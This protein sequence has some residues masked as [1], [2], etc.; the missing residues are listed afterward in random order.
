[1]QK[2]LSLLVCL[3]TILPLL[4]QRTLLI[5]QL[6]TSTPAGAEIYIAGDF[7]GWQPG[8]PA[9]RLN[10][11][12]TTGNYAITL[13]SGLGD[14][15]FKFTRGDWST[16][17]VDATGTSISNRFL[18]AGEGDTVRLQI[19]GWDDLDGPN[20]NAST[21]ESNVRILTDS[22]YMASLDRYRRVWL[23]LPPDYD[24]TTQA[25]P[26]LYMHDGQNVFDAS[27]S[28]AG[29]WQVDETLNNLHAAG[30]R[31]IIVVAIDNGQTLR[32]REYSA[33][34]NAR[35]GG[36]EGADYI[37]F[38]VEELKPYIDANYRTLPDRQH[39]GIMGSSLGGLISLFAGIEHQEVFGKVGALSPA[40]WFNPEAFEHVANTGK[41]AEMRIYQIAGTQEGAQYVEE[42]F[43]MDDQLEAAGF[44]S[45][46][47]RTL[48]HADGQHSE[49]YWAREFAAAYEWLFGDATTSTREIKLVVNE[50]RLYPNPA[51][52]SL[53]LEFKLLQAAE[54]Q[55]ELVDTKGAILQAS[56]A[57]KLPAGVHE[58]TLQLDRTAFSAGYYIC[59]LVVSDRVATVPFI[60][61]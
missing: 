1:M 60:V 55:L 44:D 2:L 40:Y 26:V 49:W 30:D 31:G 51:Q 61:R 48:E 7:Q 50:L 45:E 6:P 28:F 41:E 59:R 43:E 36:G 3:V 35:Y 11:D 14:I 9:Y 42:M 53:L 21:A 20:G 32:S 47:V 34:P 39:T 24:Q 57:Q 52:D 12:S 10:E 33:W 15:Q 58:L 22:F 5:D 54:V 23:Y 56:P 8:D 17:E 27:T 16:V 13:P 4:A 46:E 25:Y 29:E 19:E 37:D 18:A 38:I